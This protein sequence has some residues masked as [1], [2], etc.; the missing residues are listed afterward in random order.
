MQVPCYYSGPRMS[1]HL[2]LPQP[3]AY[4]RQI[5]DDTSIHCQGFDYHVLTGG[6]VVPRYAT[7]VEANLDG[8]V[9][10]VKP[11]AVR[12]RPFSLTGDL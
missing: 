4:V 12:L 6:G 5:P 11:I 9:G 3:L 10:H 2:T 7:P 1:T 8:S